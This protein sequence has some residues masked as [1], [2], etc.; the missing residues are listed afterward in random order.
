[1]RKSR[2]LG[3]GI[4]S[5]VIA[6]VWSRFCVVLWDTIYNVDNGSISRKDGRR[7]TPFS[8][9]TRTRRV[10]HGTF[11]RDKSRCQEPALD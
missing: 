5:E 8:R 11:T 10:D 7:S 3:V 9:L 4:I 6:E 2:N 1:M